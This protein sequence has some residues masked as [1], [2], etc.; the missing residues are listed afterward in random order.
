MAETQYTEACKYED[1]VKKKT[2]ISTG[3]KGDLSDLEHDMVIDAKKV[4]YIFLK[5][6]IYWEIFL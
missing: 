4:L 3:K 1:N 6:L 2:G 5:L